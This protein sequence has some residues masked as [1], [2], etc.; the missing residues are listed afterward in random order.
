MFRT[1][2][3]V[4][5]SVVPLPPRSGVTA[6]ASASTLKTARSTDR[7]AP[8]SLE[9][10]EH[11]DTGE[12]RRHRIGDAAAD[13]VRGGAVHGLEHRRECSLRVQVGAGRKTEAAG[14]GSAEIGE[15]VAEQVRGDEDVEIL[16]AA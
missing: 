9:K 10:L 8:A 12:H 3:A 16:R 6:D 13:D 15:D 7:A 5:L 11:H 2:A 4:T 1:T 14:D